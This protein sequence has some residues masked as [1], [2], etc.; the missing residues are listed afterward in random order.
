MAWD[1]AGI[2]RATLR[3]FTHLGASALLVLGVSVTL[4]LVG[5]I[6]K[7]RSGTSSGQVTVSSAF[8]QA[9]VFLG[10]GGEMK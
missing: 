6:F 7:R 1:S 5:V 4:F 2:R 3:G 9:E 10:V 8:L